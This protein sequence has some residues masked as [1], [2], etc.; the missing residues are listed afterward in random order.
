[1]IFACKAGMLELVD[2]MDLGSIA[3]AKCGFESH[4]PY[5]FLGLLAW[6]NGRH[7]RLKIYFLFRSTS[8]S[9][10]ASIFIIKEGIV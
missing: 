4:Y 1:M 6:W 2:K 3:F 10:V 7:D 8:S 9:L 5:F